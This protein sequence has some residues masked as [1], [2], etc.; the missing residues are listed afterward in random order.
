MGIFRIL[1]RF[2]YDMHLSFQIDT[3]FWILWNSYTL[4]IAI[5]ILMHRLEFFCYSSRFFENRYHILLRIFLIIEHRFQ[6]L[7][8][9]HHLIFMKECWRDKLKEFFLFFFFLILVYFEKVLHYFSVGCQ[10]EE[11]KKRPGSSVMKTTMF[12]Q[13]HCSHDEAEA[14]TLYR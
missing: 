7:I 1:L 2:L 13:A 8:Y 5:V 11:E 3:S 12:I 10:T 4:C 6:S 9:F 14:G